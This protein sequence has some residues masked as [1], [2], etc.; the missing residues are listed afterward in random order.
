MATLEAGSPLHDIW[1]EKIGCVRRR[2]ALND[3]YFIQLESE[4]HKTLLRVYHYNHSISPPPP[5]PITVF[6]PHITDSPEVWYSSCHSQGQV[7]ESGLQLA[8]CIL[9]SDRVALI[10]QTSVVI[11][12]IPNS[13]RD[14][15]ERWAPLRLIELPMQASIYFGPIEV[16]SQPYLGKPS[17]V[18][19]YPGTTSFMRVTIPDG[20]LEEPTTTTETAKLDWKALHRR[21][22]LGRSST[23]A[24]LRPHGFLLTY[25]F[26]YP[27][28]RIMLGYEFVEAMKKARDQEGLEVVESCDETTAR[29][30]A[31]PSRRGRRNIVLCDVY[32]RY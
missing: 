30:V 19:T 25:D 16:V 7:F 26:D 14:D 17:I 23:V 13:K 18:I 9:P 20:V 24:L 21:A 22:A 27:R 32:G 5:L 12:T 2:S 15:K 8:L 29:I 10:T 6:L 3:R 31:L 1:G 4:R 28:E 11:Y